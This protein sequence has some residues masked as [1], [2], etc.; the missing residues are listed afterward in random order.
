MNDLQNPGHHP[1]L[2]LFSV[3]LCAISGMIASIL[4]N[5]EI[6]IRI[7]AALVTIATGVIAC[8]HYYYQIIISKHKIRNIKNQKSKHP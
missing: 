7:F 3:I 8:R 5:L 6:T 1:L 4:N 2:G